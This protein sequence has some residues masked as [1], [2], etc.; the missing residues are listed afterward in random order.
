MCYQSVN[1][2]P[3]GTCEKAK[4]CEYPLFLELVVLAHIRSLLGT[5][6]SD[7]E[8]HPC[9]HYISVLVARPLY[10][11]RVIVGGNSLKKERK[12]SGDTTTWKHLNPT[13]WMIEKS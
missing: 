7:L 8:L 9:N 3:L 2:I 5:K 1:A 4:V 13:T 11:F 12:Q 6:E 10:P